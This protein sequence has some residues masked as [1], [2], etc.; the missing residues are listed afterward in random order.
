MGFVCFEVGGFSGRSSN[1]YLGNQICINLIGHDGH[2]QAFSS[3][4]QT[5]N[6]LC[7]FDET[8][9]VFIVIHNFKRLTCYRQCLWPWV[10]YASWTHRK[11][12]SGQFIATSRDLTSK[13]SWGREIPLFQGNLGWWNMI[14]WP[15]IYIYTYIKGLAT[16]LTT[17][18]TS[19]FYFLTEFL[20]KSS[21]KTVAQCHVPWSFMLFL[22][23][24]VEKW[25]SF[26][27][28]KHN[29]HQ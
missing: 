15:Y 14:I 6:R 22:I 20:L 24:V 10:R 3:R 12:R 29:E 11:H 2:A 13:G 18:E 8:G 16:C 5:K 26:E 9:Q 19:L 27:I 4:F 21:G 17:F 25:L 28:Y 1:G 7:R 23:L